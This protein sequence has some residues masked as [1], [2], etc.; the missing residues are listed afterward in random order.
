MKY[1]L[2]LLSIFAG[3]CTFAQ[4]PLPAMQN[5]RDKYLFIDT[6]KFFVDK[7][8]H[9]ISDTINKLIQFS[10]ESNDHELENELKIF[11]CVLSAREH[12]VSPNMIE[13]ELKQ[14]IAD[15]RDHQLK[16]V[17]ADALQVL[18]GL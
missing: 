14:I 18:G 3:F 13:S 1:L 6:N 5:F 8:L 12:L 10:K 11:R 7:H 16:F 15:A 9:E 2:S 17:E 4:R